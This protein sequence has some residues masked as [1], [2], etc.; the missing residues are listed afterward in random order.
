ML[1]H[2]KRQVKLFEMHCFNSNVYQLLVCYFS[3]GNFDQAEEQD[4]KNKLP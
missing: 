1:Q 2:T 3:S 4:L